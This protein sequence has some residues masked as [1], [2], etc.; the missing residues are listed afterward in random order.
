MGVDFSG[1]PNVNSFKDL[2]NLF[3]LCRK[4]DLKTTVHIAET[5]QDMDVDF[6]LK[7]IIPNRLGHSV[8]LTNDHIEYLLNNPIPIEICPS[9]N[10][11]TKCVDQI[12]NHIFNDFYTKSNQ[13]YPLTIC[14]DDFG[15]LNTSLSN[16]YHL[17]ST[18]FNLDLQRMFQL[19]LKSIDNIFDS[20]NE[21]KNFL[22]RKFEQF[23][24]E[25]NL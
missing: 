21:T 14:T 10:L 15:I 13:N 8:C 7:S 20:S 17:I 6:I 9:S 11:M 12:D 24:L 16:E 3:D 23:K 5:W 19:S 18:T 4:Y 22:N 25:N 1:H 2:E